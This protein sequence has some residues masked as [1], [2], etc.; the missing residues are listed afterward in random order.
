MLGRN[1]HRRCPLSVSI[2]TAND[3]VVMILTT[4]VKVVLLGFSARGL[5]FFFVLIKKYL[6]EIF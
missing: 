5:T 1:P 4:L 6:G 3:L 2:T